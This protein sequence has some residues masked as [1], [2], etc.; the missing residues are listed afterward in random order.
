[1]ASLQ[2]YQSHGIRYYRV[3]ESFRKDGKPS[4][5]VLAH[6]GRVDD[7]LQ[8]HQEHAE[9]PVKVSS[10]SAGAV[11]ALYRLTQ[12]LG[13]AERINRAI[14]PEG[15]EVQIRDSL[16]VGE[17]LVAA[18][19]ARACAPRSKR[20]FAEW[21]STTWL[22]ELMD[23]RAANLTSQH[24]W[25][26]MDAVPVDKLPEIEQELV[27]E[28]VRI[29][30]LQ[31]QALAYDTTNFFTHIASTNL[32]TELPQRGHNKQ[33]RH[34]LRQMGLALVVD[35]DTGLPLAHSLYEGARSDMR[36]FA[37]FLK[38]V[39]KRLR[40]LTGKPDQLTLVFDAGSSSRQNLEGVATSADECRPY[41]GQDRPCVFASGLHYVTAV[42]PSIHLALLA[43]AA[44]ALSEVRLSSGAVVRGWRD[45]RIIAGK[46]R[47]VVVVYSP[48]LHAG[49]LRGL[50]QTM[51][52]S[53]GE[54]EEM[55]SLARTNMEAAK[56][57]LEKIR[58][59][60]YLRALFCYKLDQNVQGAV[61]VCVWS[62]WVEYQRL[63]KRYFGLR[64]LITDRSEWSTAQ[65]I[66]AYRG[67]S[68]VE[69]AFRDLKDPRMLS[70]RPQFHWTD[71]KLHVHAFVCVMAY[72]LVTLLHRRARQKAA[73]DGSP[74]RLLTELAEVRCSRLIDM[75]GR[76]GRPRV[77][78]QIEE[79]EPGR[80]T[81]AEASGAIPAFA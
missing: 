1:V 17:S 21:A 33:G 47:E 62:D 38:P 19:I 16:T 48:K 65:I 23:F 76:K 2:A 49:Q 6:L 5:R 78:L 53:W 36:T 29:E 40:E 67:Q 41:P 56:R 75:T 13:L 4:I 3:V 24:F 12:Q 54:F 18:M 55:G 45:K 28:V 69:S 42:R 7:I 70:T 14:A 46:Q 57:K 72:L 58:N 66:E 34:D 11:T 37:E 51:S 31:L 32:R 25:D 59:R 15:K 39:R 61:Q 74:R 79:M 73:F 71:Q 30:Q 64:L 43:E 8:R 26:Q 9:V 63:I 27:L 22:P 68:R 50:H 35:Q 77:R 81:L 60:Q 20:A 52:K 10:V 80:K 44:A